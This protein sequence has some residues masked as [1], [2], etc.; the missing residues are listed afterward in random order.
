MFNKIL[1]ANRGEIACR[2]IKTA[3][4]MGIHCVAVYSTVDKNSLHVQ[5]ADSAYCVGEAAAKDSYL[6]R[7]QIIKA[8]R[9]SGAEAIHPGYGFLSENPLFAKECEEAGIIFIGPSISALEAMASKQIA[10][11]FLEKTSVPLTPGY[12]GNDQTEER[13]LQEAKNIGFPILLKAAN[14][15]GG[16]GMRAVYKEEEFHEALAG[17]KRESFASFAD[18]IMIIEKFKKRTAWI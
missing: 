6:N 12:H 1:I 17:A 7:A 3:Q 5:L 9:E 14:G 13:L 16:K 10:K 11:Q 8:A 4:A 15:G 2:I 18:E